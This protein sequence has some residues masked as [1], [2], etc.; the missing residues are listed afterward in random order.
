V[1]ERWIWL[2]IGCVAGCD[3]GSGVNCGN[4]TG[5][6]H[7]TFSNLRGA[8]TDGSYD[9]TCVYAAFDM[10]SSDVSFELS[11]IEAP[12]PRQLDKAINLSLHT[13]PEAGM[14]VQLPASSFFTALDFVDYTMLDSSGGN[15]DWQVSTG[16]VTFINYAGP[17]HPADLHVTADMVPRSTANTVGT[18]TI[19]FDCHID[20]VNSVSSP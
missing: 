19:T 14:T 13:T 3:G 16:S 5:T 2:A 15:R 8:N 7:A 11:T 4:D 18:F 9:A 17:G 20:N 10:F 6:L 1:L 12:A